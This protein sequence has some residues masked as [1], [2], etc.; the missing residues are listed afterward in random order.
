MCGES[1]THGVGE[2][3][4]RTNAGAALAEPWVP[5]FETL[6]YSHCLWYCGATCSATGPCDEKAAPGFGPVN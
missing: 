6:T 2:G 4:S 5:E 1:R 3:K